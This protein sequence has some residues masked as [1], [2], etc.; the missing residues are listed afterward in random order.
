[1]ASAAAFSCPRRCRSTTSW[2]GGSGSPGAIINEAGNNEID[3]N[4]TLTTGGG[5]TAF[6]VN[7]GTL[8]LAGNFAPAATQRTLQF[9]GAGNG[10]VSGVI[11]DGSGTNLMT[12]ISVVGPGTWTFAGANTYITNTTVTA[13]NCWSTVR[14]VPAR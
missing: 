8:K 7:G 9:G 1:M 6:V 4:F 10:T 3:G 12:G 5:G 2:I 13:G 14:S 11:A